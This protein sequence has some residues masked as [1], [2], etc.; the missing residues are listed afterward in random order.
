MVHFI[1]FRDAVGGILFESL[2]ANIP[3]DD[4]ASTSTGWYAELH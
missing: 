1:S 3:S 2:E 4:L